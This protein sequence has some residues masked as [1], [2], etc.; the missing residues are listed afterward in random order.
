MQLVQ[1]FTT[2][3]FLL[4]MGEHISWLLADMEAF[5]DQHNERSPKT[6]AKQNMSNVLCA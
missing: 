3:S 5:K 1:N 4:Y 2:Q 6:P